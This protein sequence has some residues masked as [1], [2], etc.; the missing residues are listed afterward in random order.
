MNLSREPLR[1]QTSFLPTMPRHYVYVVSLVMLLLVLSACATVD[2]GH[3]FDLK[4]FE[5]RVQHGVTTRDQ[6]RDWLGDPKST[7]VSVDTSGTHFEQWTYLHGKG[8]LPGMKDAR[9]KIL[10]I[11]FD[12]E[13]RVQGYEFSED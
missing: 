12:R 7:G 2:L 10:Q 5:A 4:T 8:R 13:G 3:E 1:I 11:K 9:F 6:V